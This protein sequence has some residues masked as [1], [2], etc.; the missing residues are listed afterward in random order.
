MPAHRRATGIIAKMDQPPALQDIVDYLVKKLNDHAPCQKRRRGKT[1]K[2]QRSPSSAAGDREERPRWPFQRGWV[3]GMN[4]SGG[5][6]IS[7]R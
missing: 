5:L 4:A 1:T 2:K 6:E 7:G 3:R